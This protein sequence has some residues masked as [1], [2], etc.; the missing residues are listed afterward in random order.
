MSQ[1]RMSVV[2]LLSIAV[3]SFTTTLAAQ[4]A[5]PAA[6]APW[7]GPVRG[8][9][10]QAGPA[11]AG[12]VVLA[13]GGSGAEIVLSPDEP[14]NVRQ[15]AT[16]LAGDIEKISGWR[17]PIVAAP[18]AGRVAIRMATL[19]SVPLPRDVDVRGMAG[20]WEAYRIVT[21]PKTVWLVGSNPRGT[22]FAAYTLSE[23]L[24]IDPLYLWTGYLP[25]H[26][27]PLVLKAVRW[28]QGPPTFKY[29]GFFHD[30]ED[31]LPRPFNAQGYPDQ[32]GD[33]PLDWYKR[34]FETALRL[35]MNMVAPY[36]RVHRRYEVQELASDWGLYYTSHHYD[37]LVSN[38]FGL[39]RFNLAAERGVRPEYDWFNNR[40][41]MLAF[42]KGGVLE[43]RHLDVIW[44]VG[45]RN[46]ED[47][48]YV[49]PQGFTDEDR[50]KVFHEVITDQVNMV[51]ELLPPGKTPL[52]HFTM[53]TEMLPAYQ[54]HPETFDLPADVIIVWPDDNDGHMR[55]LPTSLG[56][57]K[58]GIYYH[59]AYLGG[60]LSKQNVSTVSPAT[61][62]TEFQKVVQAGATEYMLVNMSE[63]RE[64]VMGVRMIADITWNAAG[65]F[66]APDPAGRYVS[67]F[68]HEYFGAG[69]DAAAATYGRYFG[70]FDVPSRLW[71]AANA[72]Q[73]LVGRLHD[74]VLGRPSPPDTG[75]RLGFFVQIP[76]DS[77]L[78][79]LRERVPR[80][81][82]ALAQE[83]RAEALMTPDQARYFHDNVALGLYLDA[84]QTRAALKLADALA[85]PDTAQ[86]WQLAWQAKAPLEQ[87]EDQLLWAEYP[88]FS[89]WYHETWIRSEFS[90][91]NPHR[92]Y[93]QVRAFLTSHGREILTPPPFFFRPPAGMTG[94][95]GVQTVPPAPP[96]GAQPAAPAPPRPPAQTTALPTEEAPATPRPARP[97]E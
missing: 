41:G 85:A 71:N 67:W 1:R 32:L 25:E 43:N 49:W 4:T 56:K 88:P 87:L 66:G 16:F 14:L 74:R 7:S 78:P 90:P 46:T 51:R 96:A 40:D 72:I 69:A 64:Y 47:R 84:D 68:S 83:A 30:D 35:R 95:P 19:G 54:Q 55:G 28:M 80:L 27:D 61:I 93:N 53:Y 39:T 86:M 63:V 37:I 22:A 24:G 42:W 23:R 65:A 15:A 20:Q 31:I 59:L 44:P 57:W 26:H 38:P 45:M 8:S 50:A 75:R 70:L 29:R 76:L 48:G 60:N 5:A 21:A 89:R 97:P 92:S 33:V 94:Q 58:H 13:G 17:P 73:Q 77:A 3:L 62:G 82:S 34:F 81:D 12:D 11:A 91:N 36:T 18:T 79:M 52:F 9:W 6:P 2:S 10:V